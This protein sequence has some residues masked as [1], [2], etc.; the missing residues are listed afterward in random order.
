[1]GNSHAWTGSLGMLA[2]SIGAVVPENICGMV[3]APLL[4]KLSKFY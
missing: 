1:M 4:V 2:F 3:S